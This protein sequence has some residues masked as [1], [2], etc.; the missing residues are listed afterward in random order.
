MKL[1]GPARRTMVS[2]F[3][4]TELLVVIAI[5]ALLASMLLPALNKVKKQ[6]HAIACVSQFRQ[7]AMP[8]LAYFSDYKEH[9]PPLMYGTVMD[10]INSIYWIDLM[11]GL[12]MKREI[13]G[14]YFDGK[15]AKYLLLCPATSI[16][17]SSYGNWDG[18][19]TGYNQS[20]STARPYGLFTKLSIIKKPSI[21]LT[22]TDVWKDQNTEEGRCLGRYRLAGNQHIAFRHNKKGTSLYLD[23]HVAQEGQGWLRMNSAFYYPLNGSSTDTVNNGDPRPDAAVAPIVDF[24]PFH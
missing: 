16:R 5:I 4:L 7:V 23:G 2:F 22:H 13:G 20:Y 3:T 19:T 21:Q 24:S 1:I 18:I 6:A 12:K 10:N 8:F 11:P 9:F 15:K 17:P 14:K